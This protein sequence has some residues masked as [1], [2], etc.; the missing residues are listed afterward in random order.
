M[1]ILQATK[2]YEK[3]MRRHTT[4]VESHLRSKHQQMKEDLFLFFR[5]TFLWWAQLWPENL[6]RSAQGL[7]AFFPPRIWHVN[8]FGYLARFGRPNVLGCRRF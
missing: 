8:S 2:S 5:E 4:I 7:R 6:R 3:W 1:N